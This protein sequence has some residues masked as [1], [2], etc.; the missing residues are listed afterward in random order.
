MTYYTRTF[1]LCLSHYVEDTFFFFLV[2]DILSP[3]QIAPDLILW[4][5][6]FLLLHTPCGNVNEVLCLLV[7]KGEVCNLSWL[8]P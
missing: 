3:F 7:A 8:S 4:D 2:Y 1:V 5:H 6:L